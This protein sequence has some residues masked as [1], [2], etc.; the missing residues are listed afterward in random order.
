MARTPRGILLWAVGVFALALSG[1]L[2]GVAVLTTGMPSASAAPPPVYYLALGD[3]L[4]YGIGAT[5]P[6][7]GYVGDIYLHE[8]T[9]IRGLQLENLGCPGA[10]TASMIAGPGCSPG[11]QLADAESFL[12]AHPGQ[13]AFATI[14]IGAN[15]ILGCYQGTAIN[16]PCVQGALGTI[17]SSLPTILSGITSAYPGLPIYGMDYY[18]PFLAV[19]LTGTSGQALAAQ[20]VT[21]QGQLNTTL[22]Q[23]YSASGIPTADVATAFQST[24]FAPTGNYAGATVPQNVADICNWTLMCTSAN[25]HANNIGHAQIAGAFEA[26]IDLPFTDMTATPG[27]GGYWIVKSDGLVT[28]RGDAVSY[29]SLGGQML[30]APINHIVSTPDGKG[31]WLVA[32]DGGIF[33]FGDAGFYGSM[34]GRILNAPVVDLAPTRDGKGYWLVASDGGIFAFGDARFFGSMGGKSLNKPVVG[35]SADDTTGGYWEVA[36]DGGVF[37]FN[38]PFYGSTGAINLNQAVNGMAATIDDE[39]YWFVAADGGV[40]AYGNAGFF[41]SAGGTTLAAP[42]VGIATDSATGG[43]W[44]VASDG[45]VFSYNAPFYGAS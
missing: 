19:W 29:G 7:T 10:T 27:G 3:S 34:G 22:S 39:G 20:S 38:A 25:V 17:A 45:G 6:A 26:L 16:L 40:F 13:V 12:E 32:S 24:D 42:I 31:Y 1:A 18:D 36:T 23:A 15:D 41:G 5:T 8:A 2:G 35:I 4:A 43:Y 37:A 11:T 21:I 9:R 44:L 30:N 14:D 33:A 28:I